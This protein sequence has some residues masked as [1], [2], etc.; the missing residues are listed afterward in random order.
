MVTQTPNLNTL[1]NDITPEDIQRE[2]DHEQSMM[3][4]GRAVAQE[5]LL[6]EKRRGNASATAG[7]RV[8][9]SQMAGELATIDVLNSIPRSERTQT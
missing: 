9:V 6:A 8:L 2:L 5:R 3:D 7:S 1:F 4:R